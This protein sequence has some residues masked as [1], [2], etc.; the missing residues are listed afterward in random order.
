M[1]DTPILDII[2]QLGVRVNRSGN[3][4]K[5]LC[6]FHSEKTPSLTIYPHTNS[7]YCFGK[8]T[9]GGNQVDFVSKFLN[10][11]SKAAYYWIKDNFFLNVK[12]SVIPIQNPVKL[13][14]PE[15]VNYWHNLMDESHQ[16]DYFHSRGFDDNFIDKEFWGWTGDRY[17]IPVWDY[18]A[19]KSDC[20]GVRLRKSKNDNSPKYIG[21]KNSNP[22]TVWGKGYCKGKKVIMSLVGEFDAAK[23]NCDGFP[24]FSIVNGVNGFNRFPENWPD[25][26]FPQTE[27]L[28]A[29][30]DKKEESFAGQMC[31]QWNRSK[32]SFKAKVVHWPL[33]VNGKDYCEI[34]QELSIYDIK[35]IINRQTHF[36]I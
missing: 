12:E 17:V 36:V 30:F 3:L 27:N 9:S 32:G 24:S 10:I 6:P 28:I 25:L 34:R 4:Y 5:C 20:L 15:I 8:C 14:A 31:Q 16:R 29:L 13:V 18:E 19:G 33:N 22:A 23:A 1:I 2:T 11:D 7:W 26:W 21:L 35:D